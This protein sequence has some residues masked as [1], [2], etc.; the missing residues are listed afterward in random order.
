MK[1]H[2][3][4]W[5]DCAKRNAVIDRHRHERADR[6]VGLPK[7][8]ASPHEGF[9]Q[10]GRLRETVRERLL[11]AL[12]VETNMGK[13]QRDHPNAVPR[14]RTR[15]E[16]GRPVFLL[17]TVVSARQALH[18]TEQRD[19]VAGGA[20]ALAA[21]QLEDVRILLLRHHARA[22]GDR[23]AEL[24]ERE[25][26]RG[27][28]HD[29]ARDTPERQKCARARPCPIERKIAVAHGMQSVLRWYPGCK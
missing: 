2:R 17:V 12:R 13:R 23:A 15:F 3:A 7:G 4:P 1:C 29:V 27:E 5:V 28:I 26:A 14:K 25:L 9:G 24:H 20:G 6:L 18:E 16:K 11:A 10:I 22:G 21:D 19:D 8:R